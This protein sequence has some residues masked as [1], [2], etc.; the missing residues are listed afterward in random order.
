MLLCKLC[1]MQAPKISPIYG[2]LN[3]L[4]CFA[5]FSSISYLCKF[6]Y[7]LYEK[8]IIFKYKFP[9]FISRCR[10]LLNIRK[11]NLVILKWRPFEYRAKLEK[12]PLL[13]RSEI[14]ILDIFFKRLCEE[15]CEDSQDHSNWKFQ[16]RATTFHK[17]A[18]L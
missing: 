18:P 13:F 2:S 4:F 16:T 7:E 8:T 12:R 17:M 11:S 10:I 9:K 6:I 15:I 1:I 5:F 3:M 14:G